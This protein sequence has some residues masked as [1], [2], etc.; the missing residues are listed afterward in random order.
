MGLFNANSVGLQALIV[1]PQGLLKPE[2]ASREDRLMTV[3]SDNYALILREGDSC[4]R[5]L[6]IFNSL[7]LGAVYLECTTMDSP[8]D[9]SAIT[10]SMSPK[11]RPEITP[12]AP[13]SLRSSDAGLPVRFLDFL[14]ACQPIPRGIMNQ[15]LSGEPNDGQVGSDRSSTSCNS[16]RG[17]SL[18]ESHSDVY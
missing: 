3:I 15:P 6:Y 4:R 5:V 16:C 10:P 18:Q 14:D 13:P 11:Q 8:F 17:I 2:E 1:S 7:L 9:D 12:H